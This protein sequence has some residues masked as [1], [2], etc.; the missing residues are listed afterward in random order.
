MAKAPPIDLSN[1][2]Y[3]P[4]QLGYKYGQPFGDPRSF[5]ASTGD[6]EINRFNQWFRSQP[7]HQQFISGTQNQG[8]G[9]LSGTERDQL[10]SLAQQAGVPIAQGQ[11]EID[12]AGNLSKKT[13]SERHPALTQG[14]ETAGLAAASFFGT[15]AL[16]A[17]L[18]PSIGAQAAKIAAP[19]LISAAGQGVQGKAPTLAGLAA[20]AVG[21][22][23]STFLSPHLESALTEALGPTGAKSAANVVTQTLASATHGQ[24]PTLGGLATAGV[25]ST[26]NTLT[27]RINDALAATL[28]PD[29]AKIAT[30]L[31]TQTLHS[32]ARGQLPSPASL[33]TSGLRGAT[34]PSG[35]PPST[36]PGPIYGP[37]PPPPTAPTAQTQSYQ[38]PWQI[39][40][41]SP[42]ALYNTPPAA[43][44]PQNLDTMYRY[45]QDQ[46][47]QG[48]GQLG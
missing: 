33:V 1:L 38:Q 8:Q 13:F 19:L 15:P 46:F 11:V 6:D 45:W 43:Q 48:A 18:A 5:T 26:V 34:Q 30:P 32:A 41:H 3:T 35:Q 23:L 36:T 4:G 24:A 37:T 25:G 29:A 10:T 7:W 31:V 42:T 27:S 2:S 44:P 22:G 39:A 9:D 16:G 21:G 28:G 47:N 17:A 40:M 12:K 20:G 14:L